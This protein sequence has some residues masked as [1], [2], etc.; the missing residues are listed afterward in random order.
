MAT[1]ADV[2]SVPYSGDLRADSLLHLSAGWNYLLPS[3]TTLYYTFDL[4]VIAGETAQA[5]T[6]F[7]ASQKAA[8]AA[9]LAYASTVTG[10]G[11][12]ET[13]N[14]AQAD[15]H[16]AA[17][18]LP[19]T[20]G[21]CQTT[22]SYS[23]G[24]GDVLTAYSA[25]AYVYLDNVEYAATN[26]APAAGSLGYEVLL[27]EI[28]HALGLDHPFDEPYPL[29][30]AEDNTNNTV[31]SYTHAGA[32]KTTFQ[33]YDLLALGWIYGNDGLRGTYGY[34]SD[35]GPSLYRSPAQDDYPASTAT[36][37]VVAINGSA[38]G[39]IERAV[40][41]DWFAVSLAAGGRYVFEMKGAAT[42]DGTL[43]GPL[44]R[45]VSQTGSTVATDENGGGATNSRIEFTA[46]STGVY[47]LEAA[48]T[49]NGGT[50]TYR[51]SATLDQSN[52]APL[53]A[54]ASI[55]AIE[56]TPHSGS[57]PAAT[58]ADG[59]PVIYAVAASPQHG[60]V[61][62]TATGQYTYT[63]A[64]DYYGADAF[65]FTVS[66]GRG[67]SNSYVAT[68]SIASVIDDLQGTAGDDN[69]I[70]ITG[71]ARLFGQA[72]NDRLQGGSGNDVLDGGAGTD[73]AAY[74]SAASGYRI[75]R[76]GGGW[77]I[78]DASGTDGVDTLVSIERL[79]FTD[80]SFDLVNPPRATAPAYNTA[81]GFLFDAVYYLLDNP[82]LV[83]AQSLA[84]AMQ[85]YFDA[86]AAQGKAPNAWFD[87]TYY[88]NK[89]ADLTALNLDDATLFMH[90]NLYGV[91]EGRSAGPKFD[92]FDGDRYLSD[93]PDVG[94][95]VDAH[96]P[97][98]LGSRSNGAIAH[99]VI[100]G[101]DEQRAA[102]D[103]V[104]QAIDL[105]YVLDLGG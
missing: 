42:G 17:C 58:D 93:N 4:S 28:G 88:E 56:D 55:A 99:Y 70:D 43:F 59:D 10:I 61:V 85:N 66:D 78:T 94:A 92:Q 16:F 20:T 3:R 2:S 50:G 11:F 72:G 21:L 75:A 18:D 95:Y 39:V 63:P 9:I 1:V 74:T 82:E 103:L 64:T 14:G 38:T 76:S 41:L 54:D 6:A 25:E 81:N 98:F 71:D 101:A 105:G 83:P 7:N 73:T 44:L 13:A 33:Q 49:V 77:S 67:G 45:L 68:V 79:Q 62:I 57:L 30:V 24:A 51:V 97:D 69:L 32:N 80:K 36:T 52:R 23:Y 40:D 104:G 100:Y 90:Y 8:A 12:A 47:Y 60:G 96:L 19:S 53:S 15:V 22:W 87:P 29:P 5:V 27:H 102:S 37:G 84:T 91:W 48:S 89:W 34:N 86:G 65:G 31:M 35:L 26:N 46:T